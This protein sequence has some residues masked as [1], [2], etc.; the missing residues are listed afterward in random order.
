MSLAYK[1]NLVRVVEVLGLTSLGVEVGG[2]WRRGNLLFQAT[3][4]GADRPASGEAWARALDEEGRQ[5]FIWPTHHPK[6]HGLVIQPGD[7]RYCF[8]VFPDRDE[9]LA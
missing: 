2:L 3:G 7:G 5:Y 1:T 8:E 9:P 4:T 6:V